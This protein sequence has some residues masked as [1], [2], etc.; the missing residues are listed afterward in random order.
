MCNCVLFCEYIF[1]RADLQPIRNLVSQARP[2]RFQYPCVIGWVWLACGPGLYAITCS[3]GGIP[4]TAS[5]DVMAGLVSIRFTVALLGTI[6]AVSADDDCGAAGW[7]VP[8][9]PAG[10]TLLQVQAIIR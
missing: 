9:P 1:Q 4:F 7:T 2:D 8:N 3:L 10:A 5:A 6:S